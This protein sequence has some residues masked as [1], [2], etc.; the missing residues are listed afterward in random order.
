MV[1]VLEPQEQELR[2]GLASGLLDLG[3]GL[4]YRQPAQGWTSQ[5]STGPGTRVSIQTASSG[6]D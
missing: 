1:K 3:Q 6:M 5:W 2:D 4:V